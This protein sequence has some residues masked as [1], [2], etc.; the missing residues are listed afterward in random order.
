MME[1]KFDKGPQRFG[2][3]AVKWDVLEDKDILPLWIADMD[4]YS[5]APVRQRM[6]E[7]AEHGTYGYT[8]S[9][10]GY[11]D[12][13]VN[14]EKNRHGIAI[15]KEWLMYSCGVVAGIS[16]ILLSLTQPGDAVLIQTPVYN[17]FHDVVK[18]NGRV[19]VDSPLVNQ[20]GSY[21]ID[22]ADFEEKVKTQKVKAFI[23]CNPHNPVGRCWSREELAKLYHICRENGVLIISDEI[24]QD[25]IRGGFSHTPMAAVAE[26]A[27]QYVITLSAPSKTFN[28]PGL[29]HSYLFTANEDYR[30]AI[31]EKIIAPLHIGGTQMGYEA[32]MVAYNQCGDWL[33]ELNA[34]LDQNAAFVRDF[35]AA[36]LPQVVVT[37][38][39]ATYLMWL[40]FAA[41]GLRGEEL[42]K[43]VASAKLKLGEGYVYADYAD[44]F[45]RVNIGCPRAMLEEAMHRLVKVMK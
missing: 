20:Q 7:L 23:L 29:H 9:P 41:L 4:F 33:D 36:E 42:T 5:P 15:E 22:F 8:M 17:P 31:Q 35:L 45:Q 37:P 2:S 43:T 14:W 21:T 24:H 18:N 40:D 11:L 3:G 44:S 16:W 12:A 26:D 27:A 32:C 19:L 13:V 10:S 34:Y 39:E 25:L 1:S 6:M 38:I 30:K 28:V